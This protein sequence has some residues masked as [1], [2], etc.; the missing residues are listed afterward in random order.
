MK[1]PR[2][3]SSLAALGLAAPLIGC[4]PDAPEQKPQRPDGAYRYVLGVAADGTPIYGGTHEVAE[5]SLRG[6][7]EAIDFENRAQRLHPEL[8]GLKYQTYDATMTEGKTDWD[9]F[10]SQWWPQSKNGTAWR[11]QIGAN[12]DYNDLSEPDTVSP[13]EKYDLMFYPGQKQTVEA[14]S[15]CEYGDF[16]ENGEDDCEKIDRPEL[17]VAGPAT[18]WEMENQGVYQLYDPESW[19]GHCNGWASYATTEPLGLPQA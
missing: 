2:F 4:A 14:V 16:V 1:N 8:N 9:V 10:P 17:E 5:L 18:K 6:K 19:W 12:Q 15:H 11:W 13:M 3:V 7:A